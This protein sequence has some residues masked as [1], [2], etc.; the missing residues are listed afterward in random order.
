[1]IVFPFVWLLAGLLVHVSIAEEVDITTT[2]APASTSAVDVLAIWDL[3]KSCDD[4]AQSMKSAM[5]NVL[6]IVT[7]THKALVFLSASMPDPRKDPDGSLR[8]KT[9]H[10]I[11][12]AMLGFKPQKEP[13]YLAQVLGMF[14]LRLPSILLTD[15]ETFSKI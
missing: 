10:K 6:E 9:V 5:E 8:Y 12:E 15:N 14:C 4:E 11:C 1:M 2:S 13:P 7:A 3:D